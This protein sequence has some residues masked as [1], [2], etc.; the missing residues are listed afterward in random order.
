M[1]FRAYF[2]ASKWEAIKSELLSIHS[3][4][5]MGEVSDFS[6]FLSAVID[7]KS[8]DRISNYIDAAK[9]DSS[10]TIL[11]GGNCDKSKGKLRNKLLV[12]RNNA[13]SIT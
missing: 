10:C 13:L 3:Q 1:T 4:L 5:T 12:L 11:A 7:E 6:I 2:P 8:F 9:A